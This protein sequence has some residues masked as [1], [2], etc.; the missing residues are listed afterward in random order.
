MSV[1]YEKRHHRSISV[2]SFGKICS[3][4]NMA[5]VIFQ[6]FILFF[7]LQFSFYLC[8]TLLSRSTK[9]SIKLSNAHVSGCLPPLWATMWKQSPEASVSPF[10]SGSIVTSLNSPV[11]MPARSSAHCFML[12]RDKGIQSTS[13]IGCQNALQGLRPPGWRV[14]FL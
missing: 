10:R 14:K 9:V 4:K 13:F 6:V 8:H 5:R 3:R 11:E 1:R 2:R 12:P 7:L